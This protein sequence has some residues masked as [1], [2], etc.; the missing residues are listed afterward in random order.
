MPS[1]C[2][3]LQRCHGC[4]WPLPAGW[5]DACGKEVKRRHKRIICSI[6][7]SA[8]CA[9]VPSPLLSLPI[10]SD[11]VVNFT[12]TVSF[13]EQ[14]PSLSLCR[15]V[16]W[17]V[18]ILSYAFSQ[19]ISRLLQFLF[20]FLNH[21]SISSCAPQVVLHWDQQDLCGQLIPAV[22]PCPY[23]SHSLYLDYSPR[24]SKI[25]SPALLS[26]HLLLTPS[27]SSNYPFPLSF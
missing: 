13:L 17:Q 14:L 11:S 21:L 9:A 27:I 2:C 15:V 3:L 25:N 12:V 22:L 19:L 18:F 16:V 7:L 4:P 10:F 26:D 6:L 1:A 5:A 24:L 8:P 23:Y 20:P